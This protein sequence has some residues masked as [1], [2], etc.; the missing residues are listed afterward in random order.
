M[1]DRIASAACA[2]VL[3]LTLRPAIGAALQGGGSNAQNAV[4]RIVVVEGE[5][6]VNVIQ[7]RCISGDAPETAAVRHTLC[8]R[9]IDPA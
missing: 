5:D 8:K 7:S 6:A 4:L 9:H 3:C 1:S 2:L